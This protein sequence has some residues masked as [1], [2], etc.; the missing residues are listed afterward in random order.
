MASASFDFD[1]ADQS[2]HFPCPFCGGRD[3]YLHDMVRAPHVECRTC[4]AFGPS[5]ETDS[6]GVHLWN[7][8]NAP[9][10][11]H[12]GALPGEFADRVQ[13][14]LALRAKLERIE[15]QKMT[16]LARK[17]PLGILRYLGA[18]LMPR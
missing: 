2:N 18:R 16:D 7:R 8:R 4:G 9:M 3:T 5:G 1:P 13:A 11:P 6:E 14:N 15:R 17:G 12:Y 10:G